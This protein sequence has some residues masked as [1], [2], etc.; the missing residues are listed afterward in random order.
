M[1]SAK[2]LLEMT[3]IR[4]LAILPTINFKKRGNLTFYFENAIQQNRETTKNLGL[5]I[6]PGVSYH[7]Y[8]VHYRRCDITR[9]ESTER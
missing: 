7:Y 4:S 8:A 1:L 9:E 6:H 3:S 2:Y 5:V